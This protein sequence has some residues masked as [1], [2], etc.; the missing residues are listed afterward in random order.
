VTLCRPLLYGLHVAPLERGRRNPRKRYEHLPRARA[1]QHRDIRPVKHDSSITFGLVRPSPPLCRHPRHRGNPGRQ[2]TATIAT[3]RPLA[4]RQ[5]YLELAYGRRPNEKLPH[6]HPRSRSWAGTG[7]ATT[8]GAGEIRQ[9][10]HQLRGAVHHTAMCSLELC[11]TIVN[12]LPLA[13]KRRRRS[14]SHAGGGGEVCRQH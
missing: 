9:N 2:D 5:S 4:S 8:H 11:G 12:R 10:D 6:N 1:G 7:L 3:V 14:P 13:Y